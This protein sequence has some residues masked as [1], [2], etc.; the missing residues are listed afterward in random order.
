MRGFHRLSIRRLSI[1]LLLIVSPSWAQE[2]HDHGVPEKLGTVSFPVSCQAGVQEKFNRGVALLHS[3]AYSVAEKT[4]HDVAE[5]DPQCAMAHW[6]MAMSYFHQL[7]DPPIVPATIAKAQEQIHLA[8]KIGTASER[9]RQFISALSLIYQ[10]AAGVAYR[11]RV[12]NYERAMS[13]LA[14]ANPKDVEAQVFYALALLASASPSDKTHARQKLA[15]DLLEPLDRAY[16]QH[17]GIPHYLIHACD[18][19]ELAPRG[20]AAARAYA[21]IA[22]SAPHALH[23]PSHIF[24]RLGLWDGS[25]ASNIATRALAHRQGDTGE[26]LHAMDYLVYAYLQVGRDKDAELVVAQLKA[27]ENLN[28]SDFKVGYAATAMPVRYVVERRQWAAAA[29][30]VPPAAAPPQV[31]AIAVWARGMGLARSGRAGDANAEVEKLRSIEEQLRASGNDYW[32]A[33]VKILG[34]EVAAWSAQAEKKPQ[35]AAALMRNAADEEDA[36]EKLPVTPGPIVPAREQLGYLL[37]EQN[38]PGLALK[39]FQTAL[40]N[41]PGRRGA[42]Q[43]AARAAQGTHP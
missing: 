39:E 17:P 33:Q 21:Q 2:N 40:T 9:E 1:G 43:G 16:P 11:T 24:T 34:H 23:M 36:V 15:V 38:Q 13:A 4:F 32:G 37:L 27:M 10:D 18:N 3:F 42:M 14:A 12:S 20:L 35:K 5:R 28:A 6:G 8:Q 26:E 41:A 22:P 7:W 30:T 25:I 29:A 31:E 19:A